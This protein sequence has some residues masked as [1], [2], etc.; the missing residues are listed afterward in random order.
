MERSRKLLE[1][2]RVEVRQK[3]VGLRGSWHPGVVVQ[4][5]DGRRIVEYD[6]LLTRDGRKKL[7][8]I[9]PLNENN[10]QKPS[11][12]VDPTRRGFI[13]PLPPAYCISSFK[14]PKKGLLVDAFYEYAWWE[15]VLLHDIITR[16]KDFKVK[17][18]F[19]E[20]GDELLCS[21][22]DVRVSQ[23]WDEMS[24][25]WMVRGS[26]SFCGNNGEL[27]ID[28][29][30]SIC[31]Q[32]SSSLK[33]LWRQKNHVIHVAQESRLSKKTGVDT[34]RPTRHGIALPLVKQVDQEVSSRSGSTQGCA[35][36]QRGI[37]A[38]SSV[39]LKGDSIDGS[40]LEFSA[41]AGFPMKQYRSAAKQFLI[42]AGWKIAFRIRTQGMS[43][44]MKE[45]VYTAPDG[46]KYYSL[47]SA[48][49][50]WKRDKNMPSTLEEGISQ[51]LKLLDAYNLAEQLM[52]SG[53]RQKKAKAGQLQET[54]V[55]K[56]WKGK[57]K[58]FNGTFVSAK[59]RKPAKGSC[60]QPTDTKNKP[61]SGAEKSKKRKSLEE[62][63]ELKSRSTFCTDICK[64]RKCGE[65]VSEQKFR[66]GRSSLKHEVSLFESK[67]SVRGGCRMQVLLSSP[68]QHK[69]SA[70]G[71]NRTEATHFKKSTVLSWLIDKGII[72]DS[73]PVRYL[74]RKDGHE[75]KRGEVTR[76]GVLCK[77]CKLLFTLSNFEAHAGSK[78]HRP[79]A[80][81]F[82]DDGR[83]ITDC[84]LQACALQDAKEDSLADVSDDTCGVCADGGELILCDYCP[85]T[86]HPNCIGLEVIPDGDWYCPRCACGGCGQIKLDGNQ[87]NTLYRCDQ[88]ELGYHSA[89]VP[90]SVLLKP[91][92]LAKGAWFCGHDCEQIFTDLRSLIGKINLLD[93]GYSWM[94]L[95]SM[96]HDVGLLPSSVEMMAEHN[97]KLGVAH[98]V[99]QECFI[100][101]ID[102]RTK[103]DLISQALYNRKS[104][105]FRLDYSGFY[106]VILENGDEMISVATIR[107]HGGRLAE[108]PL[109][110]TRYQ[111]RRQGMCRR[112]MRALEQMLGGIGV[113]KLV[114]PAVPEL[115]ETWTAAFNFQHMTAIETQELSRLNLMT[116]PGTTLLQK[117][118][119]KDLIMAAS[120]NLDKIERDVSVF[121]DHPF[122]T[123]VLSTFP[124][125]NSGRS[126]SCMLEE[127]ISLSHKAIHHKVSPMSFQGYQS[128]TYTKFEGQCQHD[129]HSLFG[130]L[131]DGKAKTEDDVQY[132]RVVR[133]TTRSKR[134]VKSPQWI[135]D[136][137]RELAKDMGVS[138]CSLGTTG[139]IQESIL[140]ELNSSIGV[141]SHLDP[142]G[143]NMANQTPV[144]NVDNSL[145]S[146]LPSYISF[147]PTDNPLSSFLAETGFVF[148]PLHYVRRKR[149]KQQDEENDLPW[150]DCGVVASP[151]DV[152]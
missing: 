7:Q 5:K 131:D 30:R 29:L 10:C 78:L 122:D 119:R 67:A 4:V 84:Q 22:K 42:D 24:G 86:F 92:G 127:M 55:C 23:E 124:L 93:D 54:R 94:L 149:T 11:T 115:L 47:A 31:R 35:K 62:T 80:N 38:R 50:G 37:T 66:K 6:E 100:P 140:D 53:R 58:G 79:S 143:S 81:I 52:S 107:V 142:A 41:N 130:F 101:M 19:P 123:G 59:I 17:I 129:P 61:S 89:C 70:G 128:I 46:F 108:M 117:Q 136:G 51:K 134:L 25:Q 152:Q 109:V 39:S 110:G 16:D 82:L 114:L 48:C 14:S 99:M 18:L 8:E 146:A 95:R 90:E 135:A 88:C 44:G 15:G 2:E 13:R 144:F 36:G 141:L 132:A 121:A 91:V 20:E 9:I 27:D 113:N 69:N 118:L 32:R 68:G 45:A 105:V 147:E 76:E 133:A 56:V 145:V 138:S 126:D 33:K 1:G 65:E 43:K 34:V 98:D 96:K 102:P 64:K 73:E 116:F 72:K 60:A 3:E 85:S 77:C 49:R 139:N 106:T 148:S 125:T 57:V 151:I 104:K 63:P 120:Q 103:I 137:L 28:V 12:S 112:L 71:Q 150:I 26:W 21:I 83:S 75:M 74:N 111:Y 97:V 87:A 40:F